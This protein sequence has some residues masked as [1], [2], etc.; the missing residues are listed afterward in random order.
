MYCRPLKYK[1][2]NQSINKDLTNRNK[3]ERETHQKMIYPNV[4]SLY[5]ATT[6]PFNAPDGGVLWDDIRKIVHEG[7]MMA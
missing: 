7:Q 1:N 6:L 5:F 3:T 2:Q 4:T